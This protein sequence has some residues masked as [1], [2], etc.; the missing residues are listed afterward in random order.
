[1]FN[2]TSCFLVK[3]NITL[4]AFFLVACSSG[5]SSDGPKVGK[6]YSAI[7]HYHPS[8]YQQQQQE[9]VDEDITISYSFSVKVNPQG[10]DKIVSLYAIDKS[11]SESHFIISGE[12]NNKLEEGEWLDND[13]A[14]SLLTT[15]DPDNLH[16][17][18]LN[19]WKMVAFDKSN[20]SDTRNFEF[21]L[22]GGEQVLNEDFVYSDAYTGSI[23]DG[24]EGLEVMTV[25]SNNLSFTF[26]SDTKRF[27]V[28]F[29]ATDLRAKFYQIQFYIESEDDDS[30]IENV[31]IARSD[32]AAVEGTPL[33]I[34]EATL[35]EI[36]RAEIELGK[37]VD[38]SDIIGIHISLL[39]EPI[40]MKDDKL[41]YSHYGVSE[42]IPLTEED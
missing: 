37:D 25:A 36:P 11:N 31:S 14:G 29:T 42:Y 12:N 9:G 41:W 5:S 24:V 19:K 6:V 15:Y 20:N 23:E 38:T 35:L 30:Q 28:N 7:A 26:D 18:H 40:E 8:F 34:G 16:R 32:S 17:F 33:N 39:D 1:M 10:N 21:E 13:F 4:S 2:N 22:A 27:K 3:L